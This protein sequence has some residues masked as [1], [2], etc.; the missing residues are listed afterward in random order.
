M[1]RKEK[2]P[3]KDRRLLISAHAYERAVQFRLKKE[4]I[5]DLFW[6]SYE[7]KLHKDLRHNAHKKYQEKQQNIKYFR[8][9]SF[10]MTAAD[11]IH[12]KFGN[13]IYVLITIYDQLLNAK[14]IPS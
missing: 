1:S 3:S 13:K 11:T 8:N 14:K 12:Y 6:N 2:K 5:E 9:G 7:E 10:I 4:D